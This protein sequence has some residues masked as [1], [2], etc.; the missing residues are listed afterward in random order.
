MINRKKCFKISK[1]LLHLIGLRITQYI[2]WMKYEI[3][4]VKK[5][6]TIK[7]DPLDWRIDEY[8]CIICHYIIETRAL[9]FSLYLN[10]FSEFNCN[11]WKFFGSRF[12]FG[13]ILT[14][15]KF[16]EFGKLLSIT[17]DIKFLFK[18]CDYF[19]RV[20]IFLF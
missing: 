1:S 6:P 14:G 3:G 18:S 9:K 20:D 8:C 4:W 5:C 16:F 12:L 7:C 2:M 17:L 13:K 10:V 15:F 19:V 11:L